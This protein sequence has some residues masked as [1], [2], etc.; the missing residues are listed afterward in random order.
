MVLHQQKQA[1]GHGASSGWSGVNIL[2]RNCEVKD[3]RLLKVLLFLSVLFLGR[4]WGL[5]MSGDC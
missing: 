4:I 3:P 2:D 5:F 1:A